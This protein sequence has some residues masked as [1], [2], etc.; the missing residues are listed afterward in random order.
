MNWTDL[1]ICLVQLKPRRVI[2]FPNTQAVYRDH[3]Y[4]PGLMPNKNSLLLQWINRL[5]LFEK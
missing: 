4:N 5:L 2:M 3:D 1:G